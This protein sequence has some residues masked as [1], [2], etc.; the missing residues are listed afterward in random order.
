MRP[1]A[2]SLDKL[3]GEKNVSIGCVMPCLYFVESEITRADLKTKCSVNPRIQAIGLD[4]QTALL[5]TFK[6]R[7]KL[8]MEFSNSNRELILAALSHPIYKAKWIVDEMDMALAKSLLEE[9][10]QKVAQTNSNI[11][12]NIDELNEIDD[13]EFLPRQPFPSTRRLSCEDASGIG[14]EIVR[15]LEDRDKNSEIFKTYPVIQKIH[16]KFNTTLSSSGPIERIFSQ[17]LII[18]TPR[19]NRISDSTFEK[20]LLLKI[21]KDLY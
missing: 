4:M 10:A 7:F 12:D 17:A 14:V 5:A 3:Q 2:Q 6:R 8:F 16:R 19:R 11:I 18:F 21:N 1:I 9:E 13:D 20:S 15:Y